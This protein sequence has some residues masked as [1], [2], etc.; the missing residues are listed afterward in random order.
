[1]AVGRRARR[2]LCSGMVAAALALALALGL[3][4]APPAIAADLGGN[5][6]GDLE[7]RIADLEATTARARATE[8]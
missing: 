7:E 1:M 6:C 2:A 3:A 5:C 8:R 4:L